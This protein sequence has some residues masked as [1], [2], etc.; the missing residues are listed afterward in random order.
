MTRLPC[1]TANPTITARNTTTITIEG[2]ELRRDAGRCRRLPRGHVDA[3]RRVRA[4][5]DDDQTVDVAAL[6]G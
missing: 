6:G 5:D 2:Q 4:G 1:V 3:G